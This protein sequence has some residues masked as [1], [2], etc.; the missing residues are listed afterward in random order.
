MRT[1]TSV[2][3]MRRLAER[4]RAKGGRLALVPTMGC[5]HAGHLRLI[6]AARRQAGRAGHVVVSIYVNPTQFAPQEDFARY[7]RDL[8][9]DKALCRQA[10]VDVLFAPA[11]RE[12]YPSAGP[13]VYST[14]VVEESLSKPMEGISRPTHFRGVATVVAKLFNIVRPRA[15]VFGAK[16]FQQAAV[17]KRMVRDLNF[18]IRVLVA[19]T[20][21]APDGLALSSR[22]QYLTPS[23][24]RQATVLWRAIAHAQR[25]VR[26]A[27]RELPAARLREELARLIATEP[28]ARADYIEFFEPESLAPVQMVQRGAHLAL[29]VFLGKT[30][31]IDNAPLV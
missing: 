12:M 9:Q 21:R 2:E 5:L 22:N 16:D 23:Q 10:G 26:A 27:R 14:Y 29:A 25:R 6:E 7:P 24:R 17:V 11:D 4:L 1:V 8:E 28:E 15:A 19:P 30:R 31:L 20:V 18:G 13:H 3:T